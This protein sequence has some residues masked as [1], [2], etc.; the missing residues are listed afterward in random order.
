MKLLF[1]VQAYGEEVTGG[2]ESHCR[3][4]AE[5]LYGRGHE[6]EV[7]TSAARSYFDWANTYTPGTSELNGVKVHRLQVA[8]PRDHEGFDGLNR[9]VIY[10][11]H[12]QVLALQETW[13]HEQGPKLPQLGPWMWNHARSY[14]VVIFFTYLYEQSLTGLKM[15]SGR[16][17]T[18]LHPL[19]HD[20][21]HL[22]LTIFDA[23]FALPTG[24]AFNVEEEASLV[25]DRCSLPK[26]SAIVG[27]GAD[28][29]A[30]G[31]PKLFRE[32]FDLGD[33]PYLV[34]VGRVDPAKGADVAFEM[35]MEY[36][37]H[38]PGPLKL[39]FIGEVVRALPKH[40]DVRMTGFVDKQL[41]RDGVAGAVASLHPS[42]FESFSMTLTEAWSLKTPVLANRQCAVLL[43]QT[44]RSQ[45]GLTYGTAREFAGNLD[46]LLADPRAREQMGLSGRRYCESR[47]GWDR[48]LDR[49]ERFL[50]LVRRR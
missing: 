40:A 12:P 18:V 7:V 41:R 49:Y 1:V 37:Q 42:F 28:L 17:P 19:A 23:L 48:V 30:T 16:V 27:I 8:S 20:E 31:D 32:A 29:E 14:D 11:P 10:G 34:C 46:A 50:T 21:P 4:F 26:P 47:Y 39:V 38:Q 45:G 9:R 25:R 36:K 2:A 22:Q 13:L 3:M 6:V 43:G 33:D 5:R 24:W 44:E 15:A 35:F